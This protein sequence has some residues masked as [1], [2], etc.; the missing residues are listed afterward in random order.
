L[1]L[2]LRTI[3]GNPHAVQ[4]PGGANST[5][6]ARQT[7]Y[8][9]TGSDEEQDRSGRTEDELGVRNKPFS[10]LVSFSL[11]ENTLIWRINGSS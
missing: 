10:V 5:G 9:N 1:V 7:P 2:K 6:S 8:L 3:I 4:N 11:T